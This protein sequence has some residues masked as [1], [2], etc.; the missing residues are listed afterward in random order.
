MS[1]NLTCGCNLPVIV[2]VICNNVLYF[3]IVNS[4]FTQTEQ[5]RHILPKSLRSRSTI[6]TFSLVFFGSADSKAEEDPIGAVPF[7]GFTVIS[8][9]FATL[10]NNSGEREIMKLSL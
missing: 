1:N 9:S 3:S 4:F 2:E 8:R 10:K 7:I 6:M 5:G